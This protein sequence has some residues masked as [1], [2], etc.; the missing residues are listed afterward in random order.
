VPR[1]VAEPVFCHEANVNATLNMLVAARDGGREE[2]GVRWFLVG[3]RNV[4][5]LPTG[6]DAPRMI[7]TTGSAAD[8]YRYGRERRHCQMFGSNTDVDAQK[9]A[10]QRLQEVRD[11]LARTVEN[12]PPICGRLNRTLET[13]QRP[14]AHACSRN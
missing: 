4:A 13:A 12:G 6:E 5:V 11:E 2:T 3:L 8:P 9:R 14:I 7:P 1:S 10:A